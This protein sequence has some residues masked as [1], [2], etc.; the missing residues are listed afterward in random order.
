METSQCLVYRVSLWDRRRHPLP[1]ICCLCCLNP[2]VHIY[3]WP[4]PPEHVNDSH[5]PLLLAKCS[6]HRP[7]LLRS[8]SQ[9]T[10]W[11]SLLERKAPPAA[12][13]RPPPQKPVALPPRW[14]YDSGIT[15]LFTPLPLPSTQPGL[16]GCQAFGVGGGTVTVR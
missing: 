16:S 12:M 8:C 1:W 5:R 7:M 2:P 6:S 4:P 14:E 9:R 10:S 3:D 15:E 13:Q 11:E